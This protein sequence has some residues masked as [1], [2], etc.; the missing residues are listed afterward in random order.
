[1]DDETRKLLDN[2]LD[3]LDRLYDRKTT[4]VDLHDILYATTKAINELSHS[5]LLGA[6]V[7][8]LHEIVRTSEAGRDDWAA[9]LDATDELRKYLAGILD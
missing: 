3:A 2:V 1:M 6:A 7:G 5:S 4:I 8:R 9:A